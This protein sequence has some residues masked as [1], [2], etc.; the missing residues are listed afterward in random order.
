MIDMRVV[1]YGVTKGMEDDTPGYNYGP[2]DFLRQALCI[3]RRYDKR[4][5]IPNTLDQ[6]TSRREG[7]PIKKV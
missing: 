3:G 5:F 4:L 7:I 1:A 6:S 2:G